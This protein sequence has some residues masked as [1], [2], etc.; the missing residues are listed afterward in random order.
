MICIISQ[1]QSKLSS[2]HIK[3]PQILR[4][5]LT[6]TKINNYF[7]SQIQFSLHN[8][9]QPFLHFF[10]PIL[11]FSGHFCLYSFQ[12]I[13][14]LKYSQSHYIMPTPRIW[15]QH[16]NIFLDPTGEKKRIIC[17]LQHELYEH[18]VNDLSHRKINILLRTKWKY[19]P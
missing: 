12:H 5:H 13:S 8:S 7:I 14:T 19:L 11:Y 18:Q 3:M 17:L 2:S 1:S 6:S 10:K 15:I 16:Q 4:D 9:S